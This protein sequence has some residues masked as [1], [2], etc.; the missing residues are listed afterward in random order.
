[1]KKYF[2][3]IFRLLCPGYCRQTNWS[4]KIRRVFFIGR[5]YFLI[6]NI[7]KNTAIIPKYCEN[8]IPIKT[9]KL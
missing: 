3:K 9:V 6:T 7:K 2:V 5:I 8:N 4:L 1:M